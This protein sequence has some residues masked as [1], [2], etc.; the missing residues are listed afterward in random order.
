VS[1]KID[2]LSILYLIGASQGL[3]LAGILATKD[4]SSHVANKYLALFL[5]TICVSL[6]DEFLFQSNYFYQYPHLIGLVWPLD[7]LYGPLFYY[8]LRLLTAIDIDVASRGKIKHFAIFAIGVVLAIPSWLL[9]GENKLA[10]MYNLPTDANRSLSIAVV[11]DSFASLFAVIQMLVY[12]ILCFRILKLHHAIVED[13]FSC[14]ELVNLKWLRSLLILLMILWAF[15][16]I[17]IFLSEPLEIGETFGIV[18]NVCLVL[19]FFVLGYRGMLQGSIFQQQDEGGAST[20]PTFTKYASSGLTKEAAPIV[21]DLLQKCMTETRPH[22]IN[23]LTLARLAKIVGVSTHHLSQVINEQFGRSFFDFINQFRVQE[24][25]TLLL[26][27]TPKMSVLDIAMES[28]FNSKTA[29]YEAFKKR[30]G[31]TPTQF[32]KSHTTV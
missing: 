14:L 15:Y 12:L 30:T 18:L 20:N 22:L 27:K 24:A 16:M 28:G 9:S 2:F 29:F 25:E 6:I 19:S 10:L 26:Q 8:Y 4:I 7:F 3:F 32:I 21:A 31:M 11:A 1:V 13:N 23:D 5:L 17:D